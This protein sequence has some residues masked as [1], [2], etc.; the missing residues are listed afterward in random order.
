MRGE[1]AS[2]RV[3]RDSHL[4]RGQSRRF[5]L[6]PDARFCG[7]ERGPSRVPPYGGKGRMDCCE[8]EKEE[9]V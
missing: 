4:H 1:R 5:S 6:S 7:G 3:I 2:G 9:S 8:T